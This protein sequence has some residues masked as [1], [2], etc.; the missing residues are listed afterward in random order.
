VLAR[1]TIGSLNGVFKSLGTRD[2]MFCGPEITYEGVNK[3][4]VDWHEFR[5]LPNFKEHTQ[6]W[7]MGEDIQA[8]KAKLKEQETS[9]PA[10]SESTDSKGATNGESSGG[11]TASPS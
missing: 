9:A 7:F 2:G 8:L 3:L 10:V 6:V 4:F 5:S 1:L 11:N